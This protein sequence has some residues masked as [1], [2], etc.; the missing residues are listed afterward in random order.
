MLFFS[1]RKYPL[2]AGCDIRGR[3]KITI[4]LKSV[5]PYWDSNPSR[6]IYLLRYSI[7]FLSVAPS[8]AEEL[9]RASDLLYPFTFSTLSKYQRSS[10]YLY[11]NCTV[12]FN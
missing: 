1:S 6:I 9:S 5:I 12:L 4:Y 2:T 3:A 10:A 7:L 11:R 8:M